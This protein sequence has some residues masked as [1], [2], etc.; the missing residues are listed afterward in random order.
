MCESPD[1]RRPLSGAI[2]T[3]YRPAEPFRDARAESAVNF[4]EL[5]GPVPVAVVMSFLLSA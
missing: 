3:V 2:T 5:A 4:R 1:D